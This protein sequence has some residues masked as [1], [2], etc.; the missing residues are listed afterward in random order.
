MIQLLEKIAAPPKI[1]SVLKR[2]YTDPRVVVKIGGE[3]ANTFQ[4]IGVQQGGNMS[5]VLFLFLMTVFAEL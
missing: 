2:L 4:K 3:K 1:A 5:P